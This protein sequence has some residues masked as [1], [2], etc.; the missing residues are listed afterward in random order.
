MNDG[1]EVDNGDERWQ[2][3]RYGRTPQS[4]NPWCQ[5]NPKTQLNQFLIRY[6]KVP[7]KKGDMQFETV[8]DPGGNGF[9][10]TLTLVLLANTEG[11]EEDERP[12]FVGEPAE[13]EKMAEQNAAQR[14][15]DH[16]AD[17]LAANPHVPKEKKKRKYELEGEGDGLEKRVKTGEYEI[18]KPGEY[19]LS[20]VDDGPERSDAASQKSLN[21]Q[22]AWMTRGLG[23]NKDMFGESQGNL[24]K[25][26]IYEEDLIK[27]EAKKGLPSD[28][29]DPF[30]D[31]FAERGPD[32][33]ADFLA[34]SKTAP[35][36]LA[37]VFAER[38][39]P[40]AASAS[41]AP[42]DPLADVFAER[43]K[44]ITPS[45]FRRPD[46][47]DPLAEFA[48]ESRR[49]S[50]TPSNGRSDPLADFAAE[51]KRAPIPAGSYPARKLLPVPTQSARFSS[52]GKSPIGASKGAIGASKATD[53]PA[54]VTASKAASKA[55]PSKS[56]E[57]KKP[58]DDIWSLLA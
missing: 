9:V 3:N 43:K 38:R 58:E 10:S 6:T 47:V 5:T 55:M 29:P 4:I 26:G 25:P 28:E 2:G 27:L 42:A 30:G 20:F 48:A 52:S 16:Y 50:I 21:N 34:E 31:V 8:A 33:L 12:Q 37:D 46:P 40:V 15:L 18:G 23:V 1:Q 54:P 17:W 24:V 45:A 14:V 41:R 19:E 36:P 35:D 13:N 11:F 44:P 57:E 22:P 53:A 32:P 49:P 39:M 51:R 56:K 7:S